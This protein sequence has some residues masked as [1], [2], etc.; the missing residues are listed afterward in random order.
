MGAAKQICCG[1][2]LCQMTAILSGVALM[3]L[4]VI[5]VLPSAKELEYDFYN[6]PVMC[7]TTKAN[8]IS[9]GG[10]KVD[11]EWSSCGEWCLSK[12]SSP[13]MQIYVMPRLA[14]SDVV[15]SQCE[16]VKDEDCSALN[17]TLTDERLCKKGECKDMSGL[18]N[19]SKDDENV[20]REITPAY[21]CTLGSSKAVNKTCTINCNEEKCTSRLDGVYLC[22]NGDC[23][24]LEDKETY[25][26]CK[27]RCEDINLAQS[28][29]VIFSKER[30]T[31]AKCS[32]ANS[33]A[34]S[35]YD[36]NNNQDW[37]TGRQMLFI[38][39]SVFTLNKI[40]EMTE[41]NM[42]DC[43][44]ATLRDRGSVVHISSFLKLIHARDNTPPNAKWLIGAEETLRI[45]NNTK[46][47][48]NAEGCVNTLIRECNAFFLT[49]ATDGKDGK[50]PDRFSCF[51]TNKTS[52]F[53]VGK[54]DPKTTYMYLLL[55]SIVPATLFVVSC[56]CLYFCSKSVG[57]DESGQLKVTLLK[58]ATAAGNTGEREPSILL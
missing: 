14:G 31:T 23:N 40:E 28:N 15:I 7:T 52:E 33:T 44:N 57:V 46:L 10:K 56:F 24:K 39:C 25:K 38:F 53:V 50:T 5:V 4:T 34:D 8:D 21:N 26:D 11:C 13:C 51:Y 6:E 45:M 42:K 41:F 54:F 29:T 20:C 49:H 22:A 47:K 35:I 9:A 58:K 19:C 18:Y 37:K 12:S 30:L 43:F 48:I 16:E 1:I 2:M 36:L 27:R 3:Y 17:I 55:G 32:F